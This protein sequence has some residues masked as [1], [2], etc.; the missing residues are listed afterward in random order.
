M[1][2]EVR[3][4]DRRIK[5]SRRQLR[6]ALQ[7]IGGVLD[8]TRWNAARLAAVHHVIAIELGRPDLDSAVQLGLMLQPARICREALLP[9]PVR[10]AHDTAKRLPVRVI[11]DGDRNPRIV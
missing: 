3:M 6:I 1:K 8:G 11:E 5:A 10:L 7:L 2:S 4:L 9:A